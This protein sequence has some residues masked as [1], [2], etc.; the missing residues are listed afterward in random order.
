MLSGLIFYFS[1]VIV[2]YDRTGE[3][4]EASSPEGSCGSLSLFMAMKNLQSILFII[5]VPYCGMA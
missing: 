3:T 5:F 4:C 1:S 2:H